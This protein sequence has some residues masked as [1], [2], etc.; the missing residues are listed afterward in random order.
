MSGGFA[1]GMAQVEPVAIYLVDQEAPV[2][3]SYIFNYHCETL[4]GPGPA[5][6]SVVA[7]NWG[8]DCIE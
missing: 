1:I 8:I 2:E 4:V 7:G 3:S 6:F 5:G